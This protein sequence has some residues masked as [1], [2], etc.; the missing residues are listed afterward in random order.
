M[1]LEISQIHLNTIIRCIA[2]RLIQLMH[3]LEV[4]NCLIIFPKSH[5]INTVE[6][7]TNICKFTNCGIKRQISNQIF[8]LDV[9]AIYLNLYFYELLP[10]LI[11]PIDSKFANFWN[12]SENNSKNELVIS[13]K[14]DSEIKNTIDVLEKSKNN[15]FLFSH[16]LLP[17]EPWKVDAFGNIYGIKDN[18]IF[19]DNSV[20]E[21]T[22]DY[23]KNEYFSKVLAVRQINQT[24]YL[25]KLFGNFIQILKN[26]KLYDK[27]LIVVSADHGIS[28]IQNTSSRKG[29][30]ENIGAI[31][32][33]PLVIKLPYQSEKQL[34]DNVSSSL[35]INQ[36]IKD[37]LK[38]KKLILKIQKQNLL[39]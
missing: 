16:I 2:L 20:R 4:K 32:N 13:Y 11:P 37:I 9:L 33:V 30:V 24:V 31:Y 19:L 3:N 21:W 8:F 10:N 14:I 17:H 22:N 36:V 27:S 26:K 6:S 23:N 15:T 25:D 7:V 1:N 5:Q 38:I 12:I 18:S 39:F 34:F 35:L 28:L 29:Q